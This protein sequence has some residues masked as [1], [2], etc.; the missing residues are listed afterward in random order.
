MTKVPRGITIQKSR[1]SVTLTTSNS[2]DSLYL[3]QVMLFIPFLS[4][5]TIVFLLHAP[6][7]LFFSIPLLA[8][9]IRWIYYNKKDHYRIKLN[10]KRLIITK[11]M[12]K[13][14]II[15]TDLK[16]IRNIYIV[17]ITDR[18]SGEFAHDPIL[19]NKNELVI[20][21]DVEKIVVTNSLIDSEQIF[22]ENKIKEWMKQHLKTITIDDAP[23]GEMIAIE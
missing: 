11:G 21:T 22:I 3:I 10:P 4:I 19:D 23:Q 15:N 12:S 14:D 16:S 17:K 2:S 5:L 8:A 18:I 1:D 6:F 13:I 7:G 9:T 20:E